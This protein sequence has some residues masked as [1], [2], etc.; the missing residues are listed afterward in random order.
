MK[1]H[2]LKAFMVSFC[3]SLLIISFVSNVLLS[4]VI[5]SKSLEIVPSNNIALFLRNDV[6]HAIASPSLEMKKISLNVIET[7]SVASLDVVPLE[8]SPVV[9]VLEDN[10]V[11]EGLEPSFVA[12]N[13]EVPIVYEKTPINRDKIIADYAGFIKEPVKVE[14]FDS[15]VDDDLSEK[16]ILYSNDKK[17]E[18]SSLVNLAFVDSSEDVVYSNAGV[19]AKEVAYEEDVFDVPLVRGNELVFDGG[20]KVADSS[21]L[22]KKVAQV[23]A[24]DFSA[25]KVEKSALDVVEVVKEETPWV[26]M[27]DL[28]LSKNESAWSVA[29]GLDN[30]KNK[31]MSKKNE[32]IKE[33]VNKQP[34]S[35]AK[36]ILIPIPSD[37]AD[38]AIASPKIVS[39]GNSFRSS[40]PS[41]L[42]GAVAEEQVVLD[43]APP[44]SFSAE[45]APSEKKGILKN[46]GDLFSKASSGVETKVK[47][48]VSGVV[49]KIA[50]IKKMPE[51][52]LAK[53][54]REILPSEI[55]LSFAPNRV[56]V[57]GQT[58]KWLGAFAR[59]SQEEDLVLEIRL[60][61]SSSYELQQKRLNLIYNILA[62]KG[63][64]GEKVKTVF[65]SREP[66]SFLIRMVS[67]SPEE[68]SVAN[69]YKYYQQ[70]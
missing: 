22:E 10:F 36:N 40:S 55:R 50:E 7:T 57:S 58:L 51:K 19:D 52:S 70:R 17:D 6:P 56:E 43:V 47:E 54:R 53:A 15:N 23:S 3:V 35:V 25:A 41:F 68:P 1:K 32:D 67:L 65:T 39:S 31:M 59:K 24:A 29:E 64:G 38:D 12:S 44:M 66:H 18:E 37:V 2:G 45:E 8:A 46:I 14:I 63:V 9:E 33:S 13:I 5:K 4:P 61:G 21:V 48:Q 28:S 20:V 69:Y 30:P 62:S 49:E 60:D 34:S 26:E 11:V 16:A 42:D 27:K